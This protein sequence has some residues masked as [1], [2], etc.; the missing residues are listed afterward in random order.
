MIFLHCWSIVFPLEC[1]VAVHEPEIG[2]VVW[3]D[4]RVINCPSAGTLGIDTGNLH[5]S[6]EINL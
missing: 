3:I 5:R 4:I 6:T 1:V 2:D